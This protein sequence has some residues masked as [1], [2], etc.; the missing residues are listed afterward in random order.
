MTFTQFLLATLITGAILII[1]RLFWIQLVIIYYAVYVLGA[2][3]LLSLSFALGW[4]LIFGDNYDGFKWLWL[5]FFLAL[6]GIYT[7][8]ALI[9][10]DAFYIVTDWIKSL[11]K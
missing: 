9:V 2:L 11:F 4:V 7:V 3:T 10:M 6:L 5:Y 8:Y 1:V